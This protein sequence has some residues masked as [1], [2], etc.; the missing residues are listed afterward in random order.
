MFRQAGAPSKDKESLSILRAR[1]RQ[2]EQERHLCCFRNWGSDHERA[3]KAFDKLK[4]FKGGPILD[5]HTPFG[6]KLIGLFHREYERCVPEG[7]DDSTADIS[8]FPADGHTKGGYIERG[9]SG[10]LNTIVG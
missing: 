3:K 6:V 5:N 8:V 4:L 2:N 9:E 1:R 7:Y 10:G